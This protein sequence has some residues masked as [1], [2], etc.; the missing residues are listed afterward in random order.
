MK[1]Y[2]TRVG[3]IVGPALA[4]LGA[5]FWAANGWLLSSRNALYQLT[6]SLCPGAFAAAIACAVLPGPRFE[7]SQAEM[8]RGMG[9]LIMIRARWWQLAL[10]LAAFVVGLVVGARMPTRLF[11]PWVH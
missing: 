4:I 6:S 9:R 3:W 8:D 2:V 1:T 5:I 11:A 7:V 10:W